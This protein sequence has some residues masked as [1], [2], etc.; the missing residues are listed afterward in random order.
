MSRSVAPSHY[1]VRNWRG[2]EKALSSVGEPLI[3]SFLAACIVHSR[4]KN[5]TGN[6]R[7]SRRHWTN[8]WCPPRPLWTDWPPATAR[9]PSRR[10][11]DPA[12]PESRR[13]RAVCTVRRR[14]RTIS[15][16][17]HRVRERTALLFLHAIYGDCIKCAQVDV[18][19]VNR[20]A[21]L[22]RTFKKPM[23]IRA[24]ILIIERPR[25]LRV[26][27]CVTAWQLLI[28]IFAGRHHLPLQITQSSLSPI[29]GA[30]ALMQ[31]K[32]LHA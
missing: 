32:R 29:R 30:A 21:V 1:Q 17:I 20:V 11:T 6:D 8:P 25:A 14:R 7:S 2:R 19:C 13:P 22:D 26:A 24:P 9:S 16:T 3:R 23:S 27:V 31:A 12:V 18:I 10:R 15:W 4:R 5:I 28:T